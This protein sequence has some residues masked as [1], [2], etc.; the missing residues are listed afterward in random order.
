[1]QQA[2]TASRSADGP[3]PWT[4][5]ADLAEVAAI[6]LTDEGR[7]DGLTRHSPSQQLSTSPASR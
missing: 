2:A 6:T 3:F 7:L 4:A 1:M 5:H